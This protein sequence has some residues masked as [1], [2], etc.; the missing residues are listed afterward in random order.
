V[1]QRLPLVDE[2]IDNSGSLDETRFQVMQALQRF[3]ERFP[4]FSNR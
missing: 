3:V 1:E 4:D 2:V